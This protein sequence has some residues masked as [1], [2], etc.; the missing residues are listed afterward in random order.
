MSALPRATPP[1]LRRTAQALAAER[2]VVRVLS[3]DELP[4][5]VQEAY[6]EAAS[7]YAWTGGELAS[8]I[9]PDGRRFDYRYGGDGRLLEVQRDGRPYAG[10]GYDDH[11][12]LVRVDRPDGPAVHDYDGQGR[13]VRTQ[14]GDASPWLYRWQ[15]GRVVEARSDLECTRFVYDERGRVVGLNQRVDGQEL[16]LGFDFDAAG[17]LHALRFDSWGQ[18]VEF[19][20]D[21]RGRPAALRWNGRTALRVGTSDDRCRSWHEGADRL[22]L[23]TLHEPH[24]GRATRHTLT[25][26]SETLWDHELLRDDAFRLVREGD[27]SLA[28]D[29]LGRLVQAADPGRAW[30]WR[31][32]L[33]GRVCAS[34][35]THRVE[36]DTEDRVLAV[37]D[38]DGERIYRYNQAGEL[39]EVMHDGQTLARCV[40]DHKGRLVWLRRVERDGRAEV[41]RYVYGPDDALLAVADGDGRPR[42]VL[43]RL[44]TGLVGAVDFSRDAAGELVNLHTD[45]GGNLVFAGLAGGV[46]VGRYD[47]DPYGLPLTRPDRAAGLGVPPVYRGRLFHDAL[48]LYRIGARW[49]CPRLRRFLT[50]DS[51][52]GAPDD[53]RLVNPFVNA[54]AQRM[55]RAGVLAEWLRQPRL[56][57]RSTYCLG[58]PVN[59]HDPNGHWSFGGVLLSLLGV[60]WTLP[61]TAFGLAVEISCLVGEVLRWLVYAVTLGHVSWQTPGFDVAASGR[62]NAFALVFRG[63]WLGSFENLLGITFGNVFFVHGEYEQ[64]P[65]VAGLPATIAPPAYGGAVTIP[66]SQAL[67]E[68]ELRH[69]N[70][71]GWWGPFFHLG[72]PLFGI[73]EWDV[74][75]HGYQNARLE[76]DARE[77]AGF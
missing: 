18:R 50:P 4:V 69:V 30:T 47:Y 44:P 23:Q 45:A 31:H 76:V 42:L 48:G 70:Q 10:Y 34:Q 64:H 5:R 58:D 25:R 14:R 49:Y 68:H 56:R 41:E 67:Y 28:Y 29:A 17:R 21:Q 57:Q 24:S 22:R 37:R 27:R 65:A 51:H 59:R 35:D 72:L 7:R 66:G 32:E 46:A 77:H 61:N 74:I 39:T 15:Q 8:L 73:Y 43:L 33:G 13:L 36:C 54:S 60:L 52:T 20:W 9:E 16:A 75:L 63:G 2:A 71:Y 19:D 55:A 53:A 62:L 40:Y 11:G 38:A 26:G 6:G 12:R 3:E 1:D